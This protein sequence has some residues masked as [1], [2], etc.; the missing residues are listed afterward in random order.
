MG[1]LVGD[2]TYGKGVIQQMYEIWDGCAFKVTTGKYF[3]RNGKDING[4]GIEPDEYVD[5]ETRPIDIT[6]Y[7]VFDYKTKP[8]RGDTSLNVKAAKQRLRLLGYY[9]GE[10]NDTFDGAAESA[11]YRFQEDNDLFAYGILDISTQVKLEN[12]FYKLK[13][14][15]DKQL[16]FAY[17]YFGG[18]VDDLHNETRD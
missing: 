6:R 4:N 11:V 12:T 5:N 10:I 8:Q 13:E 16:E 9:S 17:T 15:V 14:V 3:T 7:E 2:K 1:I 18:N